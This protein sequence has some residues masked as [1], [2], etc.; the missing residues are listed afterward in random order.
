MVI[1]EVEKSEFAIHVTANT[2]CYCK[3][4][5]SGSSIN[6]KELKAA[7]HNRF[8]DD[9]ANKKVKNNKLIVFISGPTGA[10]KSTVAQIIKNTFKAIVIENDHILT[11]LTEMYP[12]AEH[13]WK[14]QIKY[15]L[16]DEVWESVAVSADITN[17]LVVADSSIDRWYPKAR[18]FVI[19]HGYDHVIVAMDIS[20]ERRIQWIKARGER[21]FSSLDS[22]LQS[23]DTY[24][25]YQ[26]EFLKQHTPDITLTANY[27]KSALIDFIKERLN[28]APR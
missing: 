2:I 26:D 8:I 4:D 16:M 1:D 19:R 10:G 27:D 6:T 3:F 21:G 20:K 28:K 18:D 5:M 22:Y 23:M 13:E 7:L 12:D 25:H 24:Q 14:D 15:A 9:L 11:W 17:G